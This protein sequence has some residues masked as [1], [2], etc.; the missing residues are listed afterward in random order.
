MFDD[1]RQA[2]SLSVLN[3]SHRAR[4][5]TTIT[6]AFDDTLEKMAPRSRELCNIREVSAE[7]EHRYTGNAERCETI[8][9]AARYSADFRCRS[10][11]AV[12]IVRNLRS[13]DFVTSG[14]GVSACLTGRVRERHSETRTRSCF[15][16]RSHPKRLPSLREISS[17]LKDRIPCE[18]VGEGGRAIWPAS[19]CYW[20][21][22][23]F[24]LSEK[25]LERWQ[26]AGAAFSDEILISETRDNNPVAGDESER[27]LP[28]PSSQ[29]YRSFEAC[30]LPQDVSR[31]DWYQTAGY[32]SATCECHVGRINEYR[33]QGHTYS[34]AARLFLRRRSS[35]PMDL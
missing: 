2:E 31:K 35:F 29:R 21:E 23:S 19:A 3:D 20:H 15:P 22:V 8:S 9:E 16:K 17:Y 13:G 32:L 1:K 4:K 34:M 26:R 14:I 30:F 33:L 28:T 10:T 5:R 27:D 25:D 6:E 18:I 11:S 12:R 7:P 24:S